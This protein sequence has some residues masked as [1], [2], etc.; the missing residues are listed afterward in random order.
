MI[1]K[2]VKVKGKNVSQKN[3]FKSILNQMNFDRFGWLDT[4]PKN[5]EGI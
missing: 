2:W 5:V 4:G 1:I 3:K